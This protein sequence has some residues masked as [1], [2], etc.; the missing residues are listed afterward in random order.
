VH[1]LSGACALSIGQTNVVRIS[2]ESDLPPHSRHSPSFPDRWSK[3]RRL[4]EYCVVVLS[5]QIRTTELT[6]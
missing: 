2:H 5:Q 6:Q 4:G 1:G 3:A